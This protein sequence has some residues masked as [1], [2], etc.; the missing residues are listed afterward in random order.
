MCNLSLEKPKKEK[1][2]EKLAKASFVLMCGRVC[3]IYQLLL[4]ANGLVTT[5][6]TIIQAFLGDFQMKMCLVLNLCSVQQDSACNEGPSLTNM[7][8][9]PSLVSFTIS[10]QI[11]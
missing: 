8:C 6:D 7:I 9:E 3:H 1:R 10:E 5:G 4:S 2:K 11:K